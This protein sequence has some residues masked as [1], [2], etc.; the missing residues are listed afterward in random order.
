MVLYSEE[1]EFR[2]VSAHKGKEDKE[3]YIAHFE[4]SDS[5]Q[6]EFFT[7]LDAVANMRKGEMY[8]LRFNYSKGK[9][10]FEGV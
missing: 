7:K 3:Y 4:S 8:C 1:L 2:G 9:V 6:H 10:Y 5:A